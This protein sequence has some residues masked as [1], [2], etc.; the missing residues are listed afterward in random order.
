MVLLHG[1]LVPLLLLASPGQPQP[2]VPPGTR[3]PSVAIFT[4]QVRSGFAADAGDI[5]TNQVVNLVRRSGA[6][7]SVLSSSELSAVAGL[8][9]Q[10]Q[11]LDCNNNACVAELAGGLAVS[12]IITGSVGQLGESLLLDLKLIRVAGA[13]NAVSVSRRVR[14]GPKA[15]DQLLDVLPGAVE[16]LLGSAGLRAQ[17]RPAG[18]RV[19]GSSPR[20]ARACQRE[21]W[22]SP[23]LLLPPGN[24]PGWDSRTSCRTSTPAPTGPHPR[25]PPRC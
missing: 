4:L 1:L 22:T 2:P 17:S 5:L 15:A 13:V 19:Q 10:K 14:S 16:E 8:E 6:F 25:V 11:L 7:Q 9:L 21:H 20:T 12:H 3:D 24:L 18:P 23:A